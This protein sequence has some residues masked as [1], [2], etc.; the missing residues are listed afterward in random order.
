VST[1]IPCYSSRGDYILMDNSCCLPIQEGCYLSRSTVNQ[2]RHNDLAHL[3]ELMLDVVRR[4]K[5]SKKVSR[6]FVVTEG[7]FRNTG[8]ICP[9]REILALCKRHKFRLVLEDSYGFGVLGATGRGTPEHYGI[10]PSEVDIYI[11]SMSVALGTVGGFCAGE[12]CMIDHQRLAATGYVFSASL[13]PYMTGV[14]SRALQM[15]DED[16]SQVQKLQQLAKVF[17]TEIRQSNKQKNVVLMESSQDASPVIHLRA[18]PEYVR[19]NG[20]A[21]VEEK[22]ALVV[23]SLQKQNTLVQRSLYNFEERVETHPSLR[24]V[25]KSSMTQQEVEKTAQLIAAAL[26][27]E[28]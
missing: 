20:R 21:V 22:L 5:K 25:L 27:K 10:S 4:D 18:T 14:A 7:V 13:P 6:R 28:F 9:L 26:R 23:A 15:I 11:G 24:V 19:E 8:E 3:E 12:N 1:I 2:F 17:R 16:P